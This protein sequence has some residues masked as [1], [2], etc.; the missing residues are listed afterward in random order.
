[1]FD[2]NL[3]VC[4]EYLYKYIFA[5]LCMCVFMHALHNVCFKD[6]CILY[7][8]LYAC[9]CVF[10]HTVIHVYR[11]VYLKYVVYILCMSVLCR[12]MSCKIYAVRF[13]VEKTDRIL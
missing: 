3:H 1:M 7:L 4:T 5:Y 13:N 12:P 9:M 10:M 8:C 11:H 6:V 2:V